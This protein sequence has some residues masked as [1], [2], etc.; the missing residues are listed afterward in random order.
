MNNE[1]INP[2][3]NEFPDDVRDRLIE[4][5]KNEIWLYIMNKAEL[6]KELEEERVK[7]E[8]KLNEERKKATIQNRSQSLVMGGVY[9]YPTK[10][11]ILEKEF[12]R[13]VQTFLDK[14]FP[15][16]A[17]IREDIFLYIVMPL[18]EYLIKLSEM[19]FEEGHIPFIIVVGE[20]LLS[21]EKQ[22]SLMEVGGKKGFTALNL[23]ELKT[24]D[25]VEIPESL[26]YLAV[27]VENGKVM[28]GK[29][30]DEAVKQ[31]KKEGRSPLTAE[32]G[33]AIILQHPEILKDHYMDLPGS[34]RGGDYVA[35][36]WLYGGRPELYWNLVSN[37]PGAKW[38]SA[39]CEKRKG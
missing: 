10:L 24:A 25:G 27:D 16:H 7:I 32:Q 21:L 9:D 18:K 31:F 19:E 8:L 3:F 37:T 5:S 28:L 14:E 22:I 17:G 33:V 1:I 36:L 6:E 26:A 20:K 29:S 15:K 12:N 4:R 13:Q 35:F 2:F 38:G 11:S 34:R 30:A 23:L 39:S